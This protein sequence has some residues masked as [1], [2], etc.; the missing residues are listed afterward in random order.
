M[1]DTQRPLWL[2]MADAFANDV[3]TIELDNRDVFCE[4]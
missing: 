4:V 3:G 1:S 2:V